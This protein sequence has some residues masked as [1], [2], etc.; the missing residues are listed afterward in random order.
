MTPPKNIFLDDTGGESHGNEREN[1]RDAKD[2]TV[3][4]DEN[5]YGLERG[6]DTA[7]NLQSQR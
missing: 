1:D 7:M 6:R 4:D 5:D 3:S 2:N